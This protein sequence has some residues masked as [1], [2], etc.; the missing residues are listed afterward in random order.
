MVEHRTAFTKDDYE[1]LCEEVWHHNKLYYV[2]HH[3]VISDEE[4]DYLLKKLEKMEREHPEWIAPDSPTQRVNESV[5]Q[6]FQTVK[7]RIP[8]LSL[9]NTYSQEEV[10]DF[11]KRVEKLVGHKNFAFSC[12]LKMD[13]IAVAARYEEGVFVQ[14]VTR[15]D[16]KE[17]D[18]I[19]LNMRAINALP[20]RLYG[21]NVPKVLD[22]RGEVFMSHETFQKL[23]DA[24]DALGEQLWANPRNA[25]A[26]SLKLLDPSE[27][28]KRCLSVVFYG[29]AEES[30]GKVKQQHHVHDFLSSLGLPTLE[31]HALCH[32]IHEIWKFVDHIHTIRNELAYDIDGVVIKVDDIK[33]QERLGTTDKN[34][35][36]AVAYKF[37]AEQAPTMIRE[38]TVQVGRTGVLTPVAELE[39]VFLA[40]STIARATLHNQEEID[41][42][43]IRVGDTVIIEKGG[44]VIPKV[45]EVDLKRRPANSSPWTMPRHCPSCGSE[46]E[47]IVGEVAVRCP[48]LSGCPAQRLRRITYF[49]AKGAMDIE[50]LGEKV[51]EQLFQKG[52][53]ERPSDIYYLTAEQ[54]YQLEGFK[55]KSVT[56]LLRSIEESKEVSLPRFILALGIKY[57]GAGTAE[58]LAMKAGNIAH[59]ERLTKEE[60]LEIE[61]VG[62]KVAGAV[63]EFFSEQKNRDEVARLLGCGVKPQDVEVKDFGDH[64]FKGKTFVLTGTLKRYTRLNAASLIKERGG[65]VTG[66]VSKSTDYVLAGEE[67]GSKLTKAE[68][69]GVKVLSEDEFDTMI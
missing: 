26:G 2:D 53:V 30:S 55:E 41:R 48:N 54:L 3:P 51:A 16:G 8:M 7:H 19:T 43:D 65:K 17:G 22:I 56:N 14:G 34:P 68:Q 62:E 58:L 27:A 1:K 20:L 60:L 29:I 59:L 13:G 42:K 31:E 28:A 15:G 67:A 23:N 33:E 9:A 37:A 61:G 57:V 40:G 4:F 35:R 39:P 66:S 46:V 52:F 36:W 50:N 10:D 38:I 6:G 64:P 32:S 25:A 11:I 12:E 21:P 63:I 45:V 24:K 18:D 44:D 5:T 49:A 69:L 47:K